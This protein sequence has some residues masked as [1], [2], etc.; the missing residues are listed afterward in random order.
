MK[1]LQKSE[2]KF[3]NLK[4]DVACTSYSFQKLSF[5]S[6][7]SDYVSGI[8]PI[9]NYFNGHPFLDRD[10]EN[11]IQ[12][13][14]FSGNRSETVEVLAKFNTSFNAPEQTHASLEK[15]NDV[16]T[17]AVVTGQQLT[18]YGGPLF[19]IYKLMS[20]IIYAQR[21]EKKYKRSFIPVFWLA[22]EDHDFKE[23]A[24]VGLPDYDDFREFTYSNPLNEGKP[25]G[26]ILF[27]DDFVQFRNEL[28]ES[29][30]ATD[31]SE[32]LWNLLDDCYKPGT[33]FREAFGK[34]LL[35]L[36][37]KYGLV[38]AG[39]NE[40]SVKQVT[41]QVLTQSIRNAN[42]LQEALT[43]TSDK[44]VEDGYHAQVQ[45]Q[46]SNLFYIDDENNRVKIDSDEVGWFTDSKTQ[47]W[48]EDELVKA[49]EKNPEKFSP[50]VFL[51]PVVQDVLLPVIAYVAGPGE[52]AYYAQMKS[53]Y[54]S[55]GMSMPLI[56]PR[57]SATLIESGIDRILDKIPFHF[58]DYNERIEDLESRFIQE[59]EKADIEQIFS[60]WQE[61][62]ES[63]SEVHK[64]KIINID[65]TLEGSVGKAN[66]IFNS[67]LD[68]LKGKTYRAI[69]QQEKTQLNRIRKIKSSLFPNRNYQEREVAFIYFMNKYGI[70]IWDHIFDKL[71]QEIPNNH[72]QICL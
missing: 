6:L 3:K 59:S 45:V 65:P 2:I 62:V 51:R 24:K 29:L 47:R 1:K 15:L 25:V 60:E 33:T 57:F 55:F 40:K 71:E 8:K 41:Y 36:F 13:F 48:T 35:K 37:G 20:T 19:T 64:K 12:N 49:I 14:Q 22:D 72:K 53:L 54:S 30:G 43:S 42:N 5:P 66:A 28:N 69:K 18:L 17:L 44:L 52:T 68:K 46:K 38:L 63:V 16:Q 7:F 56:L 58:T 11:R 50:N 26:N 9:Q 34:L 67:E 70:D 27:D 39:S 31:F 32:N 23:A 61:R 4:G 10:V 21:W